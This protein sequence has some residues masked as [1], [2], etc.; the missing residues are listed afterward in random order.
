MVRTGGVFML[1]FG[2]RG[3]NNEREEIL[4][5]I[6]LAHKQWKDREKFFQEV[7]EPDLVDYAIFQLE[8]SRLKYIYLLKKF[9]K[10]MDSIDDFE[11]D[12][13]SMEATAEEI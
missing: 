8:A 3:K 1:S 11:L 4:E 9:R 12:S 2:D 5:N 6:R 13:K 10:E 7:S